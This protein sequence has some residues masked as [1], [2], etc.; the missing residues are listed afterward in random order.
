MY[1]QSLPSPQ[2]CIVSCVN[3][4]SKYLT[5]GGRENS[6]GNF[7]IK[8]LFL[9]IVDPQVQFHLFALFSVK[10]KYFSL[11]KLTKEIEK[12]IY[13]SFYSKYVI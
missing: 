7:Y 13:G 5:S 3:S 2:V 4:D 6:A 12:R 9:E 1:L 8:S 10:N 11:Q